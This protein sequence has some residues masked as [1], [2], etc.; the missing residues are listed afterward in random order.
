[1]HKASLAEVTQTCSLLLCSRSSRASS[2]PRRASAGV[3]IASQAHYVHR[4][5]QTVRQPVRR[6]KLCQAIKAASSLSAFLC[7]DAMLRCMGVP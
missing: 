2:K 7:I 6:L 4:G 1:M 5:S 3:P